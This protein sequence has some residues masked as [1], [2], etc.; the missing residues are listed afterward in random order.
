MQYGGLVG[1][2]LA[3]SPGVDHALATHSGGAAEDRHGQ[4]EPPAAKTTKISVT[5]RDYRPQQLAQKPVRIRLL[6]G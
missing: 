5:I 6:F 4:W 2:E 1:F 3:D